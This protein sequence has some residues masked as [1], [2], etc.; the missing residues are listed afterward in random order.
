LNPKEQLIRSQWIAFLRGLPLFDKVKWMNWP[1]ATYL[2]ESKPYQLYIANMEGFNIPIT[3]IGNNITGIKESNLGSQ[4]IL[5]SIDTALLLDGNDCLFTYSTISNHEDWQDEE[6]YEVPILVQELIENKSD[7][8]V[9][10]IGDETVSVRILENGCGIDGDWR[11]KPK[12]TLEFETYELNA[13]IKMKCINLTKKLGLSFS[14]IDLL[15]TEEDIFFL[16]V[17]PTGEWGWLT[18]D[19]RPIDQI[20]SNWLINRELQRA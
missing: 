13:E 11:V 20:I 18:N 6:V 9:T 5:K 7:I 19:N 1:Q 3:R 14:A 16:E 15:E 4:I 2:A 17:N 8:R 10:V 12:D